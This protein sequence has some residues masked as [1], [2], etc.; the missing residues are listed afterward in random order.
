LEKAIVTG[1]QPRVFT[2]H[3]E[4]TVKP[5]GRRKNV[6]VGNRMGPG[7]RFLARM[8][9]FPREGEFL[10]RVRAAAR[11]PDGL[12]YPRLSVAIGVRADVL[13][14]MQTVGDT[15]VNA[16]MDTPVVYEFR[17]RIEDFP[18]PGKNPKF[19][20]MM[21]TLTHQGEAPPA[22]KQ[23]KGKKNKKKDPAPPPEDPTKP[24]IVVESVDF[25]GPVFDAWPPSS[26]TQLLSLPTSSGDGSTSGKEAAYA[27]E[28]LQRF[29]RRAFRRPV[30]DA[31]V[32]QMMAL[33]QTIRPRAASFEVAMRDVLAMVLISPDFL[34][35]LERRHP[36]LDDVER[37]PLTHHQLASRLSYF[38]WSTMPDDQLA[39]LAADDQLRDPSVLEE[40]VR[41]MIAD[42]RSWNFVQRFTNQWLDLSGL[43]RV[44]VNPEFYPRFDDRL[45]TD[46]RLETQNFF[47][48]ILKKD[49]SALNLI[50]S[51]FAMLNGP[52][53]KHY[54]IDGPNGTDFERVAL[55]PEDHRGGLLTQAS[56]LLANST[57]EDSHPIR[58]A[59]WLLERL[60]DD[61]PPPPPPDVP[62]LKSD[63]P[64]FAALPL[65]KQLEINRTKTYCNSC[66]IGIDPWG[67]PLENYDAVGLWRTEVTK[68]AARKRRKVTTTVDATST[69]PGGHEITGIDALKQHLLE[70]D[71]ERFSRA[72]VTKVLAYGLGRS[73]EFSDTDTIDRLA[74]QF[75]ERDYRL[76]DLI[77][78]IVQSEAFLNK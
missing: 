57:G 13:A 3:A 19:P 11:V 8:D 76:S 47:A 25:E 73:P 72:I 20:G 5:G 24:L 39:R 59:V 32:D 29:M 21:I 40:Q 17:G 50:D 49:L 12:A 68:P 69:L 16:P 54:G 28:V 56:I 74:N 30:D 48:E 55:T 65:K 51:E 42:D 9:E 41:R 44:A 63:Q 23:V 36:N 77:V 35:L 70:H 1:Q 15:D 45:K 4:E 78:A 27:R 33:F 64:D 71:R 58:R 7:G 46:M 34:Y 2:H 61:P 67:V 37:Q 6:P 43:D 31:E 26:H 10:I 52:L 18:L 22:P 62:E 75:A 60:L 38:L 14:P 53:A 66:H